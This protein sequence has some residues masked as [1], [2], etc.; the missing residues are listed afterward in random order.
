ME[1]LW[2]PLIIING[3]ICFGCTE[4]ICS[5]SV[6]S[7]LPQLISPV[8]SLWCLPKLSQASGLMVFP[9][10]RSL[11]T[12]LQPRRNVWCQQL[13]KHTAGAFWDLA[14]FHSN[15]VTE[16]VQMSQRQACRWVGCTWWGHEGWAFIMVQVPPEITEKVTQ[17]PVTIHVLTYI[18]YSFCFLFLNLTLIII[19]LFLFRE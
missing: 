3:S 11:Q 6:P 7:P 8:G 17:R 4:Q 5:C 14:F 1:C 13:T 2:I 15:D 9:F 19:V 10:M 12:S 16:P 18:F